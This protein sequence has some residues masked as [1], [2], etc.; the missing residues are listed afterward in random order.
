MRGK[1]SHLRTGR[2]PPLENSREKRF[3]RDGK[4]HGA[5]RAEGWEGSL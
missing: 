1:K 4:R 2:T 5:F 3:Q